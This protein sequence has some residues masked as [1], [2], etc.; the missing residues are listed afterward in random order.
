MSAC[1][2]E[3]VLVVCV[4]LKDRFMCRCYYDTMTLS[5]KNHNSVR[6]REV[7]DDDCEKCH[8]YYTYYNNVTSTILTMYKSKK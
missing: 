5:K 1:S 7:V 4:T 6:R 8:H 2:D 3:A